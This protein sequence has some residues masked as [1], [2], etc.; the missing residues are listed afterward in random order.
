MKPKVLVL[1]NV[2]LI[3]VIEESE[4]FPKDKTFTI[5]N[6]YAGAAS[7]ERLI[8][9]CAMVDYPN[10]HCF[11]DINGKL[12]KTNISASMLREGIESKYWL[13][14]NLE[15]RSKNKFRYNAFG[16]SAFANNYP[17]QWNNYTTFKPDTAFDKTIRVH[18]HK[19]YHDNHPIY[20]VSKDFRQR[21]TVCP[22]YNLSKISKCEIVVVQ[23]GRDSFTEALGNSKTVSDVIQGSISCEHL[24]IIVTDSLEVSDQ[25]FPIENLRRPLA[26]LRER[27]RAKSTHLVTHAN[28]LRTSYSIS[29]GLSWERTIQETIY[30][31]TTI[32]HLKKYTDTLTL[33]YEMEGVVHI[34]KETIAS[35]RLKQ[36]SFVHAALDWHQAEGEWREK[37][38]AKTPGTTHVI[39]TSLIDYLAKEF[40][41]EMTNEPPPTIEISLRNGLLAARFGHQ[42][43]LTRIPQSTFN[44]DPR[45]PHHGTLSPS[46]SSDTRNI[47]C[48]PYDMMA[49]IIRRGSDE[50]LRWVEGAVR[51]FGQEQVQHVHS[52]VAECF[53]KSKGVLARTATIPAL[54]GPLKQYGIFGPIADQYTFFTEVDEPTLARN[55]MIHGERSITSAGIPIAK[56]GNLVLTQR[57]ELEIFREFAS[58]L[59][60]YEN[61]GFASP[62]NIGV[63]SEPGAGKSFAISQILASLNSQI[64]DTKPIS[65]DLSQFSSETDLIEAFRMIASHSASGK[66]PT[67]FWDEYDSNRDGRSF[68]WLQSLLEPMQARNHASGS[69]GRAIFVFAGSRFKQREDLFDCE[70]LD[71]TGL[72]FTKDSP[73]IADLRNLPHSFDTDFMDSL[74]QRLKG[75]KSLGVGNL[76][77]DEKL[78]KFRSFVSNKG[79]DF[80]SRLHFCIQISP[81]NKVGTD[82]GYL[83]KR[84]LM[85]RF[86][87][88]EHDPDVFRGNRLEIDEKTISALLSPDVRFIHGARSFENTIKTIALGY[89]PI[90]DSSR[91]ATVYALG[92]HIQDPGAFENIFRK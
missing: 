90:M 37:I 23:L 8:Q 78:T 11:Y 35:L 18:S 29:K 69:L 27:I 86:K 49:E 4:Y 3:T 67:V 71:R 32:P 19:T 83:Y 85:A 66:V 1:G 12:D 92:N 75:E 63:F 16:P 70:F 6:K 73:T 62:L 51:D 55:V 33:H 43:G 38:K 77:S 9:A 54:L 74:E 89:G 22:K 56:Y 40:T 48:A 17:N 5:Y 79:L 59:K 14:E 44:R 57:H 36:P 30:R 20:R 31:L 26:N 24:V 72:L 76:I 52:F 84:A 46:I 65:F 81:I 68:G 41:G 13:C 7:L 80:K 21:G 88:K 34:P 39:A 25:R 10:K 61:T 45:N 42:Y 28:F 53:K 64:I 2:P 91:I 58:I 47:R 50:R 60:A 82:S 15:S 87:L